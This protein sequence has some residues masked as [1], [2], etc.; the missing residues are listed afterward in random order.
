V[1]ATVY[2]ALSQCD[3]GLELHTNSKRNQPSD[4][5]ITRVREKLAAWYDAGHRDL[6]WRRNRD[7]YR[8]LVSE[9]MLVQTTVTAVVPYFER[10]VAQF[11]TAAALAAADET[12]VVKAWEGLGYYRRARQ[13]HAAAKAI[14][15]R[16]H[17]AMPD[18]SEALQALPGVGRYMAG[19]ILSFAF[20]KAAPIV[21]ANT[22]RVL[23]RLIAWKEDLKTTRSQ[24]EVWK[25]AER[26]VPMEGAG[27][28]NQAIMELGATVCAP[29]TPSC[30]LCPLSKECEAR[31]LGMQDTLPFKTAKPP[32]K[33][34]TERC[35][36]VVRD[37]HVLLVQR[38]SEGLWER[39]WEFPTIHVAGADPAGRAFDETVN[40]DEGLF[41]LTNVRARIGDAAKVVRFTVTT[42]RVELTAHLATWV[43]GDPTAGPGLSAARWVELAALPALTMGSAMRRLARWV[44][45][46]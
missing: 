5:W 42:H 35:A 34:V 20:D 13:L 9:S 38:A 25:L 45:E 2:L 36:V 41:R 21:E 8:I 15:E 3:R 33:A 7:P 29:K 19:A 31:S 22:Q 27:R 14:V 6:P 44:V 28:F 4:S 30:L 17:G 24:R 10:F 23:A 12:D 1:S 18:D 16:H 40:L 37:K 43:D 11:P 26:L 39:F 32:P 46:E